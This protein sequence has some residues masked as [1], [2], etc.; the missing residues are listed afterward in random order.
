MEERQ[1]EKKCK[2]PTARSCGLCKFEVG[3]YA[4]ELKRGARRRA[5]SC[6]QRVVIMLDERCGLFAVV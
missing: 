6:S 5:K 3:V 4:A 1:K 2:N